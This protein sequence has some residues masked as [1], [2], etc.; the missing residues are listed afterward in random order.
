MLL[1][2]FVVNSLTTFVTRLELT[3]EAKWEYAAYGLRIH[4]SPLVKAKIRI[5]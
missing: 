3:S 2:T 4:K 1:W 5:T